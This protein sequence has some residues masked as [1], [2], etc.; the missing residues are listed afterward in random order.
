[1]TT[2]EEL[3]R[4]TRDQLHAAATLIGGKPWGADRGMPRI[5]MRSSKDRKIYFDFPDFPTGDASDVLGGARLQCRID[6][7]GQHA[8]WYRGQRAKI[9]ESFQTHALALAAATHDRALAEAIMDHDGEF[10]DRDVDALSGHFSN[11]RI[12]AAR[13]IVAALAE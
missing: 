3:D 10:D 7:C 6:D 2:Q 4:I 11:G 13:E 1:M 12:D 8:N 9:V 5:Y